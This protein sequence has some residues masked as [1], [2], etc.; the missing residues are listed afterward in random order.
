MYVTGF[1]FS[2]TISFDGITLTRSGRSDVF[3]AKY[4]PD[5]D[6]KWAKQGSGGGNNDMQSSSL[7]ADSDGNVYVTGY[8]RNTASFDG[9]TIT[10]S[11]LSF[12]IVKYDTNGDAEWAKQAGKGHGQ[13]IVSDS[14]GNVYV[15][16]YF[17]GT[18]DFDGTILTGTNGDAFV[19]KYDP[20]GNVEWAKQSKGDSFNTGSAITTD[21][22]GNVYV[23]GRFIN[24]AS[25]GGTTLTSIENVDDDF[26]S[27]IFVVKYDSDGSVL[28]AKQ[29]GGIDRDAGLSI[30]ADPTNDVYVAGRLGGTANFDDTILTPNNGATSFISKL[31][32]LPNTYFQ[33][34][35]V[36]GLE[37][38]FDE[39]VVN[40]DWGL[41]WDQGQQLPKNTG[42]IIE[43]DSQNSI[44]IAI[45]D[46]AH[47]SPRGTS[48]GG[49]I[50]KVDRSGSE[51]LSIDTGI[52]QTVDFELD[53]SNNI[54]VCGYTFNGLLVTGSY[55]IMKYD[56]EGN[57]LWTK[58]DLTLDN[59]GLAKKPNGDVLISSY[60][61]YGSGT[62]DNA[63]IE[64]G[65]FLINLN[66]ASGLGE[67]AINLG[68]SNAII[69][70][71]VDS[72]GNYYTLERYIA[73]PANNIV[74][75]DIR[76]YDASG[77]LIASQSLVGNSSNTNAFDL[78]LTN[79][80]KVVVSGVFGPSLTLGSKALYSTSQTN[81]FWVKLNSGL[82]VED[83]QKLDT[84]TSTSWAYLDLD[85]QDN[86]YL[87]TDI[88]S[89]KLNSGGNVLWNVPESSHDFHALSTNEAYMTG[90]FAN[91]LT[92]GDIEL[93]ADDSQD[94]Y[95]LK[96]SGEVRT[97]KIDGAPEWDSLVYAGDANR[98][99]IYDSVTDDQ[100]N[101][102]VVGEFID[103]LTLG[104]TTLTSAAYT[105][106]FVAKLDTNGNWVWA[107]SAGGERYDYGHDIAID[108]ED[109]VY[110]TGG[111]I[112]EADFGSITLNT[113]SSFP[114]YNVFI[115]KLDS[116]GNW[117]WANQ[118][119][120]GSAIAYTVS[121]DQNLD[122]IIAGMY[123]NT[124]TF[125]GD[126]FNSIDAH[127]L[128]VSKLDNNGNWIWTNTAGGD[129]WDIAYDSVLDDDGNIY[130]AGEFNEDISLNQINLQEVPNSSQSDGDLLIAKLDTNGNWVWA[131]GAGSNGS[132]EG[133]RILINEKREVFVTGFYD[134]TMTIGDSQLTNSGGRDIFLVSL[135]EDGDWQ[136]EVSSTGGNDSNN[137][138]YGLS[139]LPNGDLLVAGGFSGTIQFGSQAPTNSGSRD[140]FLAKLSQPTEP[141]PNQFNSYL[142]S[143]SY[144]TMIESQGN[145]V[146]WDKLRITDQVP[147]GTRIDYTVLDSTCSNVLLGPDPALSGILNI[148]SIP[149][150]N[151]TLCLR[152][153]LSTT[154]NNNQITPYL[155]AWQATYLSDSLPFFNF[156][157][158]VKTEDLT[159]DKIVNNV[160]ISTIT[161]ETNYDNNNDDDEINL[162]QSDLQVVKAVDLA[163]AKPTDTLTYTINY[164]NNGPATA[165]SAVLKDVLPEDVTLIGTTP[166][167]TSLDGRELN[168]EL[169]DL[170]VGS[171][172][173]ITVE[174]DI[175]DSAVTDGDILVNNTEITSR[176]L[177]IDLSNNSD[178][179]TTLISDL[180]NLYVTKIGQS[181]VY[182]GKETSYDI[183]YGNNGNID[184][185]DSLIQDTLDSNLKF[186]S[187]AQTSGSISLTCDHTGADSEGYGGVVSCGGN[188]VSLPVGER[189]TL[190]LIV[191]VKNDMN[192]IDQEEDVLNV[193][194]IQ[195]TSDELTLGDNRDDFESDVDF[196]E[197]AGLA[198]RV[199]V[200]HNL[201][202]ERDVGDMY[203]Q[204]VTI[205]LFGQ[206]YTGKYY[207]PDKEIH[208]IEY[209][210][211]VNELGLP[212]DH[213]QDY[214]SDYE[215]T[216][217]QST[218]NDGDYAFV[219]L[220]PGTYGT[221][222]IQPTIYRSTGSNGGYLGYQTD[223]TP[224][225]DPVVDGEG[226]V[227]TNNVGDVNIIRDIILES[228]DFSIENNYG[229]T[230]G[231]L[232][233]LVFL[234][235][236]GN[237]VYE[238]NEGEVGFE[239]VTL[240]LWWDVNEDGVID[241][242]DQKL[243]STFTNEIGEYYFENL[244]LNDGTNN[245]Y[246]YLVEVT[247]VNNILEDY[248][249]TQGTP[250]QD[251]NSQNENGY[252]VILDN[253]NYQNL[254]ADFGY[255]INRASLGDK[256]WLD[257]NRDGIQ[258]GEENGEIGIEGVTVE[259]YSHDQNNQN[260]QNNLISTTQ[261]DN[262]G[263]YLFEY[264]IPGD[265]YV[266]FILPENYNFTSQ[267]QGA[268]DSVDSDSDTTTGE[269]EITNLEPGETDLTW[270]S[271]VYPIIDL[272]LE[273]TKNIQQ[274][275]TLYVGDEAIFTLTVT[276]EGNHPASNV[277][278]LDNLPTGLTYISDNSQNTILVNSDPNNPA[279][280]INYPTSYD[281]TSSIWTIGDLNV[282]ESISLEITVETN[283]VGTQTNIAE[284]ET[285]NEED[286]DSTPGDN[287]RNE[288]TDDFDDEDKEVVEVVEREEEEKN[289]NEEE[290]EK[291]HNEQEDNE[292]NKE[293]DVQEE[294]EQNQEED[295][296]GIIPILPRTGGEAIGG[297]LFIILLTSSLLFIFERKRKNREKGKES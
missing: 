182:L 146:S 60:N 69:D 86:L 47:R 134:G 205:L 287:D 148:S 213:T 258:D 279:Y 270:D 2:D 52:Y 155:D 172:G 294:E 296:F 20:G 256:V 103:T 6:I 18:A 88:G 211:A 41:S 32:P 135:N 185:L 108:S 198:G 21:S 122:I 57:L 13:G 96:V 35:D 75:I 97:S 144:T 22:D 19:A 80:Q 141:L 110:V 265:Y 48:T 63:S 28:W 243:E 54:Y 194:T 283:E 263:N 14:D 10:D 255:E 207:L 197:L 93:T 124:A 145:L 186:I 78:E 50:K 61:R 153:D 92:A 111:F 264:L 281:S 275:E 7:S 71:E 226:S 268:D 25:F 68:G 231:R 249:H 206:D 140:I 91:T 228:G 180:S 269:T 276:N 131:K 40:Y 98:D 109:N 208:P 31:S 33:P 139:S 286:I 183:E 142:P 132:E 11:G 125:G 233:N 219:S 1:F 202:V 212:L 285:T 295:T 291:E 199:F 44:Y 261:T 87:A 156:Q 64:S 99:N 158:Q 70:F 163:A 164:R 179:I 282:G 94:A 55:A 83:L 266:K 289:E 147:G 130:I 106:V 187:I 224:R 12:Y 232:G 217:P 271:G 89:Y 49:T 248:T 81:P 177:D 262:L 244:D 251:N 218:G 190:R 36:I 24:T 293:K 239:N 102:Y 27:D 154:N 37:G 9:I 123:M 128:F 45:N 216:T 65:A 84:L 112:G 280:P 254:T 105:D 90:S 53:Q 193:V 3:V 127:D 120:G 175:T 72:S 273:K 192:L 237:G 46:R 56:T 167:Y 59:C 221:M 17:S 165:K 126:S 149:N 160:G 8:F 136:W 214:P 176:S 121:I 4:G 196:L 209:D 43:Q 246:N 157:V 220:Q 203:L 152:A 129:D 168:W 173:T 178:S 73:D 267:N 252:S 223:G 222:E 288:N 191:E 284:I 51:T 259:L 159:I 215:I 150:S 133:R 62:L 117:L 195:T 79:S 26:A 67:S 39:N 143:G 114:P 30:V 116:D 161:P 104:D 16:G 76:K 245:N 235:E 77:N 107:Q 188:G 166:N 5:G 82:I 181:K 100:G 42:Q 171:A 151:T 15:T 277:S 118:S 189:G 115:T 242:G 58:T 23:T 227:E 85:E 38:L 34:D 210:I 138:S 174:V 290:N 241:A 297:T 274:G 169:G 240:D 101:T 95:L 74:N 260:N 257:I 200:D 247:D 230:L 184:A 292:N 229:E 272:A 137:S 170:P 66:S 201:N 250:N 253:T 162:I 238:P 225:L 204:D 278:V 113:G 29:A 234:D 236:N 119:E